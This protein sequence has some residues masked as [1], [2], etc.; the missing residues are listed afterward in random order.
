MSDLQV[1]PREMRV[2]NKTA[3]VE[4]DTTLIPVRSLDALAKTVRHEH[5]LVVNAGQK[6]LEHAVLCGDALVEA[7]SRVKKGEWQRWVD[8]NLPMSRHTANFYM[9]AS[10]HVDVLRENRIDSLTA[11]KWFLVDRQLTVACD[12]SPLSDEQIAQIRA[13]AK[14]GISQRRIAS[15]VGCA[16]AAVCVYLNDPEHGKRKRGPKPHGRRPGRKAER[17]RRSLA[18]TDDLVEG[19]AIWLCESFASSGYPSEVTD[20]VR[21]D[22]A[23]ALRAAFVYDG[24]IPERTA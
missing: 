2:G 23:A 14:E 12:S 5:Q 4:S 16:P 19:M 9:R 15:M 6:L 18:V 10:V 17:N 20:T 24:P 11:A 3:V 22:A 13:L 7:K 21:S 8:D 1:I